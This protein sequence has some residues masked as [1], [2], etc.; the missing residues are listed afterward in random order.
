MKC[1]LMHK[2]VPVADVE[3]DEITGAYTK[4]YDVI[5]PLHL[6]VGVQM[7]NGT[8]DRRDLHE[9]WSAR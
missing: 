3:F 2:N 5:N 6:P 8:A 9:W 4:I 1:I 7:R